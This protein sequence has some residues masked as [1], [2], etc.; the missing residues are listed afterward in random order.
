MVIRAVFLSFAL[1]MEFPEGSVDSTHGLW[2][3]FIS[4]FLDAEK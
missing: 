2:R 1:V 4:G 3:R